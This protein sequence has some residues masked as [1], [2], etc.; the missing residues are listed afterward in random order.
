[1]KCRNRRIPSSR[2]TLGRMSRSIRRW[3]LNNAL[4]GTPRSENERVAS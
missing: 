3:Y 1:M 4:N 2:R